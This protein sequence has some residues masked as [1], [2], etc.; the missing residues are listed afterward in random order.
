LVF[1]IPLPIIACQLGWITAEVGR[2]PWVVY[3]VMKTADAISLT[4][5]AGEILF[6]IILFGLIYIFLGALYIFLVVREVKRGPEAG[7]AKKV[8]A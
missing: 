1:S 6:S 2:Q 3:K 8:T 5:S 7:Q 4:V